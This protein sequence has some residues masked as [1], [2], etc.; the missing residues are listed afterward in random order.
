MARGN[1]SRHAA[2]RVEE[3]AR[4]QPINA[5][6][7][8]CGQATIDWDGEQGK[9]NSFEVEHTMPVVKYPELEF[10]PSNRKPSHVRCNR[11]KG[12]GTARP[13]IGLTS[14]AW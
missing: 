6:C 7:I 8:L 13:G 1:N 11:N 5:P 3:K 10:E 9:P 2:M 4:W 12:T 14:E